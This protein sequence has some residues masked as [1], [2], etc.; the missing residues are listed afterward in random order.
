MFFSF[1]FYALIM[2]AHV[3]TLHDVLLLCNTTNLRIL[4]SLRGDSIKR[5]FTICLY[6]KNKYKQHSNLGWKI[7]KTAKNTKKKKKIPRWVA[8]SCKNRRLFWNIRILLLLNVHIW[9]TAPAGNCYLQRLESVSSVSPK[10]IRYGA[11]E[12]HHHDA[13]KKRHRPRGFWHPTVSTEPVT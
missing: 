3:Y 13:D 5:W 10:W 12:C 6:S 9:W 11:N 2:Y 8:K 1:F 4:S 7:K